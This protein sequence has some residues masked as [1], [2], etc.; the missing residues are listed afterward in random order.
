MIIVNNKYVKSWKL[1]LVKRKLQGWKKTR[2]TWKMDDICEQAVTKVEL[3]SI[4]L[5]HI[6]ILTYI[7]R[8]VPFDL[9]PRKFLIGLRYNPNSMCLSILHFFLLDNFLIEL[10]NF[11]IILKQ[12]Q[13][14]NA[15]KGSKYSVGWTIKRSLQL[16]FSYSIS[17]GCSSFLS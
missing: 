8:L 9:N 5:L 11:N 6:K 15:S 16:T 17:L 3:S 12:L 13:K 4:F 1:F 7:P 2:L 14:T 10:K